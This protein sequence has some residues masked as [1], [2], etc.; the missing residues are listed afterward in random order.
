MATVYIVQEPL[1]R[2]PGHGGVELKYSLEPARAF[3]ALK[4]LLSWDD[5]RH[6]T[7][8]SLICSRL[9]AGLRGFSADD[10]LLLTGNPAAIAAAAI[11]AAQESQ[12]LIKALSWDNRKLEYECLLIDID[13]QPMERTYGS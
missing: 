12:G 10:Y 2:H 1:K 6:P 9:R 8:M 7:N 11:L 13:A 3:G 5:V 4:V